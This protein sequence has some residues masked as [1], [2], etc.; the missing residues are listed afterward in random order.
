[1][2][3]GLSRWPPLQNVPDPVAV[4]VGIKNSVDEG[5]T[6]T[7]QEGYQYIVFGGFTNDGT[8]ILDGELVIL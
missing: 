6:L 2:S 8:V 7:I 3:G 4:P 5:D 1:M